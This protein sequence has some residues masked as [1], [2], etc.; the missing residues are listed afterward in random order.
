[1]YVTQIIN[2]IY[3]E[4]AM[5]EIDHL[6][7]HLSRGKS[8]ESSK[9]NGRREGELRGKKPELAKCASELSI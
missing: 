9:W 5:L 1:M 3:E 6:H 4:T 2:E 8:R 7:F